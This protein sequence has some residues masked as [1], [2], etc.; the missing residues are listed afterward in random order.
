MERLEEA[1]LSHEAPLSF[2]LEEELKVDGFV[3]L[4]G[5]Q[6]LL[7]VELREKLLDANLTQ[8]KRVQYVLL[9]LHKSKMYENFLRAMKDSSS[10]DLRELA[11]K[12]VSTAHDMSLPLG[13]CE[14]D[15]SSGAERLSVP[16]QVEEKYDG[17]LVLANRHLVRGSEYLVPTHDN[18]LAVPVGPHKVGYM[19]LTSVNPYPLCVPKQDSTSCNWLL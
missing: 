1:F 6:G 9:K 8:G 15:C 3:A 4:L 17:A 10:F 18:N 5:E 19:E 16:Q 13:V 14:K 12:I 7:D 11:G 2:L